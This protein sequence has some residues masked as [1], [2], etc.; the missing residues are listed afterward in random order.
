MAR[1]TT[2]TG[3]SIT[4]GNK[5]GAGGEGAV[6]DVV[7]APH[8]VAKIYH[9]HRLNQAL[10]DKVRAMVANPPEDATRKPPLNHVSIAWPTDIVL[11]GRTFAGYLMPKLPKSDDL[12]DLLQPQ[13]RKKQHGQLNHRHL[14]RTARNLALAMEAIHQKN[15]VIGDVNFKNALF[16][17]DALITIVDCDSMQ[18]T[19]GN[20]TVHRCIVGMPEYTSPELQ[21]KDF[22]KE[23]RT[24]NHDAFGLAVLIF[25][26]LMQGFHPFT[27]RAKPG[28]PDVEQSHVY[29]IQQQIFPY[30]DNQ[31][32]EPPRV[33]P[34]FHALPPMLQILFTRAFT[35]VNNRPTPKEWAQVISMIEKRLVTCSNDASHFYPSDGACVICEIDYN[36]GRR[37]RTT[38]AP[39]PTSNMQVPLNSGGIQQSATQGTLFNQSSTTGP[40]RPAPVSTPNATPPVQPPVQSGSRPATPPRNATPPPLHIPSAPMGGRLW[41][42]WLLTVIMRI[43]GILRRWGRYIVFAI[44]ALI[45]IN[46]ILN[47][48]NAIVAMQN[49]ASDAQVTAPVAT[50]APTLTP[51]ATRTSIPATPTAELPTPTAGIIAAACEQ[52]TIIGTTW[53]MLT[54]AIQDK[55]AI[56]ALGYTVASRYGPVIDVTQSLSATKTLPLSPMNAIQ[57]CGTGFG[58]LIDV[59]NSTEATYIG[60]T[61]ETCDTDSITPVMSAYD[62]LIRRND[63]RTINI[64]SRDSL[65]AQL[66]NRYTNSSSIT[67]IQLLANAHTEQSFANDILPV[68]QKPLVS[69]RNNVVVWHKKTA[70]TQNVSIPTNSA[71]YTPEGNIGTRSTTKTIP[72]IRF[73]IDLS[74]LTWQTGRPMLASEYTAW[75]ES[76][77]SRNDQHPACRYIQSVDGSGSN[78][79]LTYVPG[80][81]ADLAETIAPYAIKGAGNSTNSLVN[82]T[83]TEWQLVTP[84][85]PMKYRLRANDYT[86]TIETYTDVQQF[87]SR[88]RRNDTQIGMVAAVYAH[89]ILDELS[90]GAIPDDMRIELVPTGNIYVVQGN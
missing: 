73:T 63:Q 58:S 59:R 79:V 16:N 41:W 70:S 72:Q 90:D 86:V 34:S 12:Y 1:Y 65:L 60:C 44:I 55:L 25:Q 61:D 52:S 66:L 51:P 27:G 4:L 19:E 50:E 77:A 24:T 7:G 32:Y 82:S 14:Y 47:G 30:L 78:L 26:L 85:S 49:S 29:C 62:V 11:N 5:L 35:Q 3:K 80:V 89:Q 84:Y 17:D 20:G 81:P 56:E 45:L 71:W 15:Y 21:G 13:Q 23:V 46:I 76:C 36:S 75:F 88:L 69:I 8:L 22:N 57:T 83:T 31:P 33:A 40:L 28:A 64:S 37:Q 68:L 48:Y 9:A 67:V 10:A 87:M 6:Y 54:A 2:A 74:G 42:S 18:V 38:P 43:V 39:K 53:P